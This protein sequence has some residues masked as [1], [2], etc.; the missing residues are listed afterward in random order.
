MNTA[1][2]K[3]EWSGEVPLFYSSHIVSREETEALLARQRAEVQSGVKQA[4][5]SCTMKCAT[6]L[7]CLCHEDTGS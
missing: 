3:P 2:S 4:T 5:L 1:L 7:H 6:C